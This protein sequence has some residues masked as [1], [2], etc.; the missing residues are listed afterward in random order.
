MED[1]KAFIRDSLRDDSGN[2]HLAIADAKDEYMGTV[3]LKHIDEK[4]KT[5][6]FGIAIRECAMGKG[7]SLFA[8]KE[9]I[10]IGKEERGL[11]KIY[12]CLSPD[13]LRALRFYEKQGYE[14]VS[15]DSLQIEVPYTREEI[16]RYV[17][18][19]V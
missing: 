19:C 18:Y 1:C 14:R 11:D 17:W 5:A 7:T 10:R 15:F 9:M 8:M 6:E 12:W 3:S 13:N 2:L 16:D 4:H